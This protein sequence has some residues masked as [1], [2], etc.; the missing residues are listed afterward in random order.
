MVL[1][2]AGTRKEDDHFLIFE[3]FVTVIDVPAPHAS[4]AFNTGPTVSAAAINRRARGVQP[5][6]AVSIP[7]SGPR[8]C[9]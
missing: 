3:P 6:R 5:S 9:A 8:C 4:I 7:A 2:G 1:I